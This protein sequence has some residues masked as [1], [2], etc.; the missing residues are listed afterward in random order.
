ME[1]GLLARVVSAVPVRVGEEAPRFAL[2]PEPGEMVHLE[3]HIGEAPIVLLFFPLAYSGVCTSEMCAVRDS[4]EE[5]RE[6]DAR[7]FAISVDSPFVTARFRDDYDLPFPVL[8]DFNKDVSRAYGVL[9]DDPWGQKGVA[10]RSVFVI[11]RE[12]TV[13]WAWISEDD[14]VEP[15]Y[16]AIRG[17][18]AGVA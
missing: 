17:A 2:P 7:V 4:W 6:L 3:R 10:R 11:D 5:F 15:D 14:G 9:Y 1:S 16:E 12:G 13:A 8:S 18:L